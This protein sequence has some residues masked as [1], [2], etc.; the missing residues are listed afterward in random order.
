MSAN[1]SSVTSSVGGLDGLLDFLAQLDAAA[2][3]Y[4]LASFRDDA[5]MVRVSVPGERWEVEF[6]RDGSIEVEV[7]RS[8]GHVVDDDSAL[9]RLFKEFSD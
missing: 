6:M 5:L 7:F 3:R 4:T 1:T 8:D 2:I 9:E